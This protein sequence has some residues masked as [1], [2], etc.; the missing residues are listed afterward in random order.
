MKAVR[1]KP[2]LCIGCK[3]CMTECARVIYKAKD[4]EMSAIR[5]KEKPE[6]VGSYEIYVCSHCGKC[7]PFCNTEAI[8]QAKTGAVRLDSKKCVGCYICVGFCPY[9][10]IFINKNINEP[11][12]CIACGACTRVCP[13]G[14]VYTEEISNSGGV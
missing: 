8:Y 14:A 9:D 7:I 12:K 11:I 13:T 3:A 10:A 5:I 4:S 6:K 2:E 1:V